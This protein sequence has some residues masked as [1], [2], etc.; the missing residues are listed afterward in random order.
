MFPLSQKKRYI[1]DDQVANMGRIVAKSRSG[2]N[3]KTDVLITLPASLFRAMPGKSLHVLA[4]LLDHANQDGLAWP[5]QSTIGEFAGIQSDGTIRKLVKWLV[6]NRWILHS[7]R[8][9]NQ[10]DVYDL[11]PT[12]KKIGKIRSPK[13][14]G[15]GAPKNTPPVPQNHTPP[16]PQKM[17]TKVR[18][19]NGAP[20]RQTLQPPSRHNGSSHSELLD[21]DGC[22]LV[23][24]FDPPPSGQAGRRLTSPNGKHRFRG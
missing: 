23:S 15:T 18:T 4:C 9:H 1:G 5:S 20:T 24:P 3:Q 12:F 6:D 10:T 11:N 14:W 22:P 2:R 19:S 13:K 16:V 8:W 21:S 7:R 17:G